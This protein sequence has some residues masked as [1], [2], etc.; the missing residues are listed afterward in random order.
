[1]LAIPPKRFDRPLVTFLTDAEIDALLAAPDR[2]TWIGRRDH[3]LL[4]LAVQTGL[5]VSELTGL[6]CGDVHLGTGAAR[7]LPR[8]GPQGPRHPADHATPSTVLRDLAARTRRRNPPTRC[9]PHRAAARSAAT[10]SNA[11]VAKHAATAASACPSLASQED[12][13][14]RAAPHRRHAPA[15]TPAWTPP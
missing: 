10:P 7:A 11:C 3:A 14:A 4:V 8:Q 9:S 15:R 12:H 6:T 13:P 5:R 1:M 2:T